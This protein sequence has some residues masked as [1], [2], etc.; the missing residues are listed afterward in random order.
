MAAKIKALTKEFN[1][2]KARASEVPHWFNLLFAEDHVTV[3]D[4]ILLDALYR[5]RSLELPLSGE[6]M[7]PC[8]DLANH[9]SEASAR[10]EEDEQRHVKLVLRDG[11]TLTDGQEVTIDYGQGKSA[12]EML[13]SYGFIDQASKA[14]KMVL[15]LDPLE[16]DPLGSAKLHIFR[17]TQ[18]SP[19]IEIRDSEDGVPTWHA[20]FAYL[21]A[22]NEEDGL[23]FG[24]LQETDGSRQLK[25]FWQEE[26][27]SDRAHRVKDLFVDHPLRLVFELRAVSIVYEKVADQLSG[28]DEGDLAGQQTTSRSATAETASRHLRLT[29]KDLLVRMV[30]ALEEQVRCIVP[31]H[32]W[33]TPVRAGSRAAAGRMKT[34]IWKRYG[35]LTFFFK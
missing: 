32:C 26:D 23:Q 4:W 33:A 20:P 6:C 22:V 10:F 19:T 35:S 14:N 9:S 34:Q 15:P 7:V 25:L 1:D 5:S 31:T 18:N 16:D 17:T 13:F 29:E 8:L 24:V 28:M 27:E 21:L 3:Q 11:C 2:L 12:A 30:A